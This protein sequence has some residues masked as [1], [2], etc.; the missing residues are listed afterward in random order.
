MV[1][2]TPLSGGEGC[3]PPQ[4]SDLATITLIRLIKRGTVESRAEMSDLITTLCAAPQM[5]SRALA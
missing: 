4:I 2:A 3:Y 5:S 1:V